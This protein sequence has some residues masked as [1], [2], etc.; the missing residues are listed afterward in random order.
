MWH[1]PGGLLL[2]QKTRVRWI[3]GKCSSPRRIFRRSSD[4]RWRFNDMVV[5]IL[6]RSK[7]E[8]LIDARLSG[9]VKRLLEK[10]FP[11]MT[12]LWNF[13]DSSLKQPTFRRMHSEIETPRQIRRSSCCR[14]SSASLVPGDTC[15]NSNFSIL[16]F[17]EWS[18]NDSINHLVLLPTRNFYTAFS[19]WY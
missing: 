15:R 12:I 13:Q 11:Q 2:F 7:W 4:L 9:P 3:P 5:H 17:A 18:R 1:C 6:F 8:V 19:K 10:L 16:L 14:S